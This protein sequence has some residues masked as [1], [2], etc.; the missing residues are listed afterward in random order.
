MEKSML[1]VGSG[2]GAIILNLF[3]E[4]NSLLTIL[5]I[6]VTLDYV[7]GMIASGIEGKLSSKFGLRGIGRKVLIFSLVTVAHLIDTILTNQHF[8]RNATIIFYLCNEMI[9]IIENVGRAGVPVPEFL[10]KAVEVLKKKS[11]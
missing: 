6:A 4:W 2:L 5:L 11:K 7:T 10:R 9:S 1:F 3:G 8:I